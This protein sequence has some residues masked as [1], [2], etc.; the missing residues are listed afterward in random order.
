M[1]NMKNY[2]KHNFGFLSFP[3]HVVCSP[4]L[5]EKKARKLY[6]RTL[7]L[8]ILRWKL[9]NFIKRIIVFG[10]ISVIF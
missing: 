2:E 4:P 3:Y 7:F 6:E 1:Y 10:I 8:V 5:S 9:L